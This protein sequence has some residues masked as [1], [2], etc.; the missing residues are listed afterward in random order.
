[1]INNLKNSE[2][3]RY[4]RQKLP[5]SGEIPKSKENTTILNIT[6]QTKLI[7]LKQFLI[8]IWFYFSIILSWYLSWQ[9]NILWYNTYLFCY[10]TCYILRQSKYLHTHLVSVKTYQLIE[11]FSSHRSK[12][13]IN[14]NKYTV[15]LVKQKY[16]ILEGK[17]PCFTNSAIADFFLS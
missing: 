17:N 12:Y 10:K 15:I 2:I 7:I 1:M 9:L 16:K 13:R 6:L 5:R 4:I 14:K 8:S 3:E 11:T